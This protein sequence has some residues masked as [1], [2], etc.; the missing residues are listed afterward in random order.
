MTSVAVNTYTQS[1]TYVA[2][3]LLKSLKDVIRM[4]GLDPE[5]FVGDWQSSRR[6]MAAWLESGHLRRVILEIFDP[7]AN[8]LIVRWDMDIVYSYSGDGVFFTDTEQLRY[9][10]RKAGLVPSQ[11]RYRMVLN[12]APGAPDVAGWLSTTLRSTD[13]FSRQ[14]LGSTIEHSGL[15]AGTSYWRKN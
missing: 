12:H 10:I 15:G 7:A 5:Q 14:S 9:H 11:A 6:A 2:D 4:S 8:V 3:N 13:G 1:V